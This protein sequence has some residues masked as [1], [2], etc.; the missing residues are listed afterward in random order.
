MYIITIIAFIKNCQ[1][2]I[3]SI[4]NWLLNFIIIYFCTWI[5]FDSKKGLLPVKSIIRFD[6]SYSPCE[7]QWVSKSY[8][9]SSLSG[10]TFRGFLYRVSNRDLIMPGPFR[11]SCNRLFLSSLHTNICLFQIWFVKISLG[12]T[13]SLLVR[14]LEIT[15]ITG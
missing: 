12:G 13:D 8:C 4:L 9:P 6:K 11:N 15:V 3:A 10:V 14:A 5:T 2:E 7:F 1:Y